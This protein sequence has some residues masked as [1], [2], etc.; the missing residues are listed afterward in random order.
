MCVCLSLSLPNQKGISS[1][2]LKDY[3]EHFLRDLRRVCEC[4]WGEAGGFAKRTLNSA[5]QNHT[6]FGLT[7]RTCREVSRP[8]CKHNT[9]MAVR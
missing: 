4:V 5:S 1:N 2:N 8:F 6:D 9:W 3:D 7:P